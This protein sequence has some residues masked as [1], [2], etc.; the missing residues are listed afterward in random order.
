MTD[1]WLANAGDAAI[2]IA[3]ER[4]VRAAAP[5]ASILHAAYQHDVLADR[6]PDLRLI[7]PLDRLLGTPWSPDPPDEQGESLVEQ[8]DLV[9]SQGGGFLLEPYLPWARIA[10]LAAV[11]RRGRPLALVGQTIG[12]FRMTVL[13]RQL[14]EILRAAA[15]VVARDPLTVEHVVAFGR[16]RASV[17][18]GADLALGLV[19]EDPGPALED[20]PVSVVLSEHIV[21]PAGR[22][23]RAA[24]A[25]RLLAAV[26]EATDAPLSLWSSAQGVADAAA[27]DDGALAAALAAG[28]PERVTVERAHVD[29]AALV[30]RV[31]S[32]RAV[33]SMRLHP[34]LLAAAMGR[35][36]GAVLSGQKATMF[37]GTALAAPR[38]RDPIAAAVA[39]ALAPPSA[40]WAAIERLRDRFDDTTAA[41]TALVQSLPA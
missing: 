41:L 36:V 6:Y 32:S 16:P 29:A 33:V 11:A 26:L 34:A 38:G 30:E 9:L 13:R 27:D 2:A 24:E 22:G 5:G 20:G 39:A 12:P 3:T 1:C 25:D 4:I 7:P 23:A 37:D 17:V 40:P 10:A 14:G 35:P 15:L 31:R 28:A 21:D 8:A 19:D 18:L